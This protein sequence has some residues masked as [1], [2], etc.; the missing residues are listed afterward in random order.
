MNKGM[1]SVSL[2]L[3]ALFI[4]HATLM[5]CSTPEVRMA[6]DDWNPDNPAY[7]SFYD[8]KEQMGSWTWH[9]VK[10]KD[11]GTVVYHRF[12]PP[13]GPIQGTCYLIHGYLE[14]G[15]LRMPIIQ[16]LLEEG[17]EAIAIDLPGHGLSSGRR[18]HIDNFSTYSASLETVLQ[19]EAREG[20]LAMIAHSTGC[21]T[22]MLHAIEYGTPFKFAI[23][24][25]PLVRTFLWKPS[26]VAIKFFEG[27]ISSLPGRNI[28][29]RSYDL[30][31]QLEEDPFYI[32]RA[33]ISWFHALEDYVARTESWESVPGNYLLIQ[34][35]KDTVV[36]R[37]YNIPF[38][39]E[40]LAQ[41]TI[42]MIPGG[43][44]HLLRDEGE[45]GQLV[46]EELAAYWERMTAKTQ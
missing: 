24:E 35:E 44:H 22:T 5:A 32:R 26:I 11:R 19:A 41:S 30:R 45:V 42:V 33:P 46:R 21:A 20:P 37:E 12:L 38:L 9:S 2:K 17:W 14:H 3:V 34:G 31:R 7:R 8:W 16:F 1:R 27:A 6:T 18:G 36:D 43:N 4:V 39:A 28:I 29:P 40:H 15:P 10:V 25:A 23:F 13:S